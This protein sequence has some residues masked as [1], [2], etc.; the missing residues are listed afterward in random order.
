MNYIIICFLL[1]SFMLQLFI[2]S[3][4]PI[5]GL[6][7]ELVL[8][9]LLFLSL[10]YGSLFGEIYGFIAGLLLDCFTIHVFGLRAFIFTI[11]GYFVG[12]FSHKLDEEKIQVQVLLTATIVSFYYLTNNILP[13]VLLS[14]S[15]Q[16][17]IFKLFC[18][19]LYN[20]VFA[21]FLF[22]IMKSVRIKKH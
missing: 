21:P 3:Y 22:L 7:P 20:S 12:K 16:I 1:F 13:G 9:T 19:I 4:L 2:L 18:A 11:I 5:F 8:L 17:D 14:G 6:A 15:I 10:K